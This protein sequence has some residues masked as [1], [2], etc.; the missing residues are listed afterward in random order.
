MTEGGLWFVASCHWLAAGAVKSLSWICCMRAGGGSEQLNQYEAATTFAVLASSHYFKRGGGDH[1]KSTD[2]L[3]TLSLSQVGTQPYRFHGFS[4][5]AE[6][7][8]G[9][10]HWI[11]FRVN[12]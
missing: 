5:S 12:I 6:E 11:T 4:V 8:P 9:L 2:S 1:L 7:P 10:L 3:L